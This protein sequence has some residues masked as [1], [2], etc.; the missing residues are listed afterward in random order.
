MPSR[1][2]PKPFPLSP[3]EDK[4]EEEGEEEADDQRG[5][6]GHVEGE[7]ASA[8]QDVPRQAADARE[9]AGQEDEP[10]HDDQEDAEEDQ[11]PSQAAQLRHVAPPN[12][13][14]RSPRGRL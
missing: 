12:Q 10:P 13:Y 5:G 7:G 11:G 4:V 2:L 6:Q 3:P 8:D 1:S 14:N 9:P